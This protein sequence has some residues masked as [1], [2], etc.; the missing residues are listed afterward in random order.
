MTELRHLLV[1]VGRCRL[2]HIRPLARMQEDLGIDSFTAVEILVAI[3]KRYGI[4]ILE[5][6]VNDIVTF[7]DL[8]HFISHKV[9]A[10]KR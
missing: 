4:K 5:S 8:V 6:E 3:E 7:H 10:R 1:D 2:Q 9:R